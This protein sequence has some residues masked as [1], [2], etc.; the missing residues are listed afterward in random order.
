MAQTPSTYTGD[1]ILLEI[2]IQY[3]SI[4]VIHITSYCNLMWFHETSSNGTSLHHKPL[5]DWGTFS[6]HQSHPVWK[7]LMPSTVTMSTHWQS[8]FVVKLC[9]QEHSGWTLSTPSS[10]GRST[11]Q[12]VRECKRLTGWMS[13]GYI[14]NHGSSL[15]GLWSNFNHGININNNLYRNTIHDLS[16]DKDL[17]SVIIHGFS[18]NNGLRSNITGFINYPF[19]EV[20]LDGS[21]FS[22][23]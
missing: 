15:F 5:H 19:S 16:I 14:D 6:L 17:W 11:H 10:Y 3:I 22:K 7:L 9:F 20:L 8:Q 4:N 12:L 13:K 18:T 1:L 21:D 2:S 23:H